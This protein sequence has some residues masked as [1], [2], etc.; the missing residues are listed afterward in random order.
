MVLCCLEKI[1]KSF[2]KILNLSDFNE[3]YLF[4]MKKDVFFHIM[5]YWGEP[6]TLNKM[7]ENLC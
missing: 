6:K 4:I 7:V 3:T 5:I 1:T 2:Q